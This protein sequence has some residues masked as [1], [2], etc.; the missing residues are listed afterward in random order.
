MKSGVPTDRH[1]W[2]ELSSAVTNNALSVHVKMETKETE[3]EFGVC[4]Q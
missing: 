4:Y 3:T 1:T 2:R